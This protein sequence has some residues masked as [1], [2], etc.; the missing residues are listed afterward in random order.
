MDENFLKVEGNQFIKSKNTGALLTVNK[1][2]LIQNEARKKLGQKLNSNNDEIN[3]MKNKI[4]EISVEI[5]EI[6]NFLKLLIEKKE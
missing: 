6:K 1:N 2:I 3:N 5:N 4:D